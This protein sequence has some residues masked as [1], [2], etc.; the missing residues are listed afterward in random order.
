MQFTEVIQNRFSV[1]KFKK[2]EVP[3]DLIMQVLEIARQAPSAVNFQPWLFIVVSEKQ[4]L[5]K[6]HAVYHREWFRTAPAVIV[7]CADHSQSWKRTSDGKDFAD[8][9]LAIAV[10]H[11]ILAATASGL[12]S[13]WVCNFDVPRCK[14]LLEL[15]GHLEPIAMVP[16]G[17]PDAEAPARKRKPLE[18]IVFWEKFGG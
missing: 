11:L 3:R 1:R 5:N 10:D 2:Q 12:G 6:L 4:Q 17:F 7:A 9:D 8:V 14:E 13:C 16:I 15:P 18:E